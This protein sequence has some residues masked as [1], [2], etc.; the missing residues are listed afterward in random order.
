M[1]GVAPATEVTFKTWELT[2]SNVYLLPPN[3]DNALF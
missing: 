2:V 1:T 3:N